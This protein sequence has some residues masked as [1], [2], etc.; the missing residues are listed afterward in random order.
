MEVPLPNKFLLSLFILGSAIRQ[1]A[2]SL[3]PIA[4]L[5]GL[6]ISH[7]SLLR[8]TESRKPTTQDH[9]ILSVYT[10]QLSR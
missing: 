2:V 4:D 3:T 8:L 9:K 6:F 5:L 1:L 10:N 7:F